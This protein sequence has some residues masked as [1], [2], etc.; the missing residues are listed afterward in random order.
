M[1]YAR[2]SRLAGLGSALACI[3]VGLSCHS[4]PALRVPRAWP[5][6]RGELALVVSS[7]D[8]SP[9]FFHTRERT[10]AVRVSF[11]PELLELRR[12]RE[13]RLWWRGPTESAW[14]IA[15]S[16]T[17]EEQPMLF[18]ASAPG[19]VALSASAVYDDGGEVFVPQSGQAPQ[20][21]L[22]IDE[23]PPAIAWRGAHGQQVLGRAPTLELEWTAE[24][25]QFGRDP[26]RLAY[27]VDGGLT[28][29]PI[30]EK[31]ARLGANR[32]SWRVPGEVS[33]DVI[34]RVTARDL[35]GNECGE[36]IALVYARGGLVPAAAPADLTPEGRGAI[37]AG[38]DAAAASAAGAD[39]AAASAGDAGDAGGGRRASAAA[40]GEVAVIDH[41]PVTAGGPEL[42]AVVR[43]VPFASN[44]LRGASDV[45][46]RWE[47]DAAAA[48]DL[49]AQTAAILEYALDVDADVDADAD[50]YADPGAAVTTTPDES[51]PDRGRA[52]AWVLAGQAAVGDLTTTWRVPATT[53]DR[54]RLRLVVP[55]PPGAATTAGGPAAI[56]TATGDRATADPAAVPRPRLPAS[57]SI[58]ELDG[59]SIDARAPLVRARA[60][61][62]LAGGTLALAIDWE[63]GGCGE[64][65]AVGVHLRRRGEEFW[66]ALAA[67]KT[68]LRLPA[69][70]A[71]NAAETRRAGSAA[72][73]IDLR[74]LE[75]TSYE[76]FLTAR[77]AVGN[78]SA[79]PGPSSSAVGAFSLDATPP[80][81]VIAPPV[82]DWIAGFETTIAI[83]LDVA[84][85]TPPL[86]IEAREDGGEWR[87]LRRVA[88]LSG[89]EAVPVVLPIGP[90]EISLRVRVSDALGNEATATV[91]SRPLLGA[92]AWT[93]FV[94]STPPAGGATV[95]D[96]GAPAYRP[97]AKEL[98]A[99]RLHPRAAELRDELRVRVA[100]RFAGDGEWTQVHESLPAED[101]FEWVLPDGGLGRCQLRARLYRGAD[102]VAETLSASF[103]IGAFLK[104]IELSEPSRRAL[105][106]AQSSETIFRL[107]LDELSRTGELTA[108]TRAELDR[109]ARESV[110]KYREAIEL[111]A[112]NYHAAYALAMLLNDLDPR[113]NANEAIALLEKTIAVEPRHPSAGINL[114][115]ISIQT[116]DFERARSTLERALAIEESALARFNLGLALISLEEPEAARAEFARALASGSD[117]VPAGDAWFYTVY[118]YVIE[119]R[120]D[121]ARALYA[122]RQDLIPQELRAVLEGELGTVSGN[123]VR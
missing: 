4:A 122:T 84:D 99:W 81:L 69:A 110:A 36:E 91:D 63:D 62:E 80:R 21:W 67:E 42:E 30:G 22:V 101:A 33:G 23:T 54:V 48:P 56:A 59:L 58:D 82:L 16:A 44:C 35:A 108:A 78:E 73:A 119:D 83:D 89:I 115:A 105:E 106:I 45:E 121:L 51:T 52:L 17:P 123:G 1:K 40:A 88:T 39:A 95:D 109:V 49:P 74:G 111:D 53:A 93:T 87:E 41:D 116:G 104:P 34:V 92:I 102:L 46:V 10:V 7:L 32:H 66:S 75:E 65:A 55:L 77:D 5:L 27:S 43:L 94:D 68:A 107:Q 76:L 38:A 20:A 2:R 28:W 98:V 96:D 24:E 12:V 97:F 57:D 29:K 72:V 61:P 37:V 6:D 9:D 90:S 103:A 13:Y 100:Y 15:C 113:A 112:N 18:E 11:D 118:S 47:I 120:L 31:P 50:S 114:G 64:L 60:L 8:V 19:R 86:V 14:R 25:A 26:M 71:A 117:R 70:G 79:A 85:T 3:V